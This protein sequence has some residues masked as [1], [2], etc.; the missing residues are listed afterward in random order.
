MRVLISGSTGL[1]GTYLRKIAPP[2]AEVIGTYYSRPFS[3]GVKL[4]LM[5]SMQTAD[6]LCEVKP[7]VII[8]TAGEG[9]VDKVER[10]PNIYYPL[11]VLAPLRLAHLAQQFGCQQFVHLSSNAVFGKANPPYREFDERLPVNEYG[12]QK[13]LVDGLLQEKEIAE[14]LTIIRPILLFGWESDGGRKNWVTQCL[15]KWERG[16]T[17]RAVTDV[18]TQPLYARDCADFI[19]HCVQE[20]HTGIYHVAGKSVVNFHEFTQEIASVFGYDEALL[21]EARLDDFPML[22]PR[23]RRCW[24]GM[25]RAIVRGCIPRVL[26]EG[27]EEMKGEKDGIR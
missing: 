14:R 4:D 12:R 7:D 2:E 25:E 9:S 27:L 21:E 8:H 24:Y 10:A 16:E 6:L 19:W 5:S 1:L 3:G 18:V 23:P 13:S 20:Q 15:G 22:C 26:R 17:V 11:N